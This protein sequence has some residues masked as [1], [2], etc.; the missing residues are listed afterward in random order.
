LRQFGWTNRHFRSA[1]ELVSL[2]THRR[3]NQNAPITGRRI[4]ARLAKAPGRFGRNLGE[5]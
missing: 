4:D 1:D 2:K 3:S 5:G